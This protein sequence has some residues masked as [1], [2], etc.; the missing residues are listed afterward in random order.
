MQSKAENLHTD[1]DKT[2]ILFCSVFARISVLIII[3]KVL[4]LLAPLDAMTFDK[5]RKE[6]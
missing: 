6:R 3:D 5:L 4:S 1:T 2:K